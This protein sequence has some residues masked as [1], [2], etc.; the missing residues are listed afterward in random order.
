MMSRIEVIEKGRDKQ[1]LPQGSTSR[2]L[3]YRKRKVLDLRKQTPILLS[4]E[5]IDHCVEHCDSD[6]GL[7]LALFD[8]IF[9]ER[10]ELPESFDQLNEDYI[11]FII[12]TAIRKLPNDLV[13]NEA[14]AE[15]I[16]KALQGIIHFLQ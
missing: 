6:T 10:D 1:S 4:D 15:A 3:A 16:R 11:Y 2:K 9:P 7:A 14:Q 5:K 8:E 13:T 12:K